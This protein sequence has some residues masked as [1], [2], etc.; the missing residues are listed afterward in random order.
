MILLDSDIIIY[1]ALPHNIELRRRIASENPYASVISLVEVLGFHNISK[2]EALYFGD[3]FAAT[4]VIPISEAVL[5]QA[6][7]IRQERKIGLGDSLIA[8]TALVHSLSLV[9]N[10]SKDFKWIESL[11]LIDPFEENAC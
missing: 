7:S 5:D 8:S 3:F 1:S 6:I 10:N 2:D 4:E 11:T 9:T